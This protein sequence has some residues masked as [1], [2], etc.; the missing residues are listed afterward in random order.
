M[1]KINQIFWKIIFVVILFSR[2]DL[3]SQAC[4]TAG[5]PL[6]GSLEMTSAPKGVLQFGLTAEHN[7]LKHVLSGSEKLRNSERE[8]ISQS[9]L[10]EIN[11]GL[12]N[13]ISITSLLS[14]IRQERTITNLINSRDQLSAAG[15]GDIAL[16]IKYSLIPFDIIGQQDPRE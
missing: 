13:N 10:L 4:C 3:Y 1:M 9:I 16:L 14:Y 6:L 8:R 5:T 7:S 15:I 2:G 11:Y 12:T